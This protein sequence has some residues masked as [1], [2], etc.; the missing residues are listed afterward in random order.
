MLFLKIPND[1]RT[2]KERNKTEIENRT[3]NEKSRI[4]IQYGK[5]Y[6]N[7]I[8]TNKDPNKVR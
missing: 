1:K 5:P 3:T 4:F 6:G 7:I 8:S 2:H